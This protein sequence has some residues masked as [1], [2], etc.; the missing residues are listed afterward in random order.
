MKPRVK[1]I[2]LGHSF[3]MKYFSQNVALGSAFLFFLLTMHGLAQN[4]KRVLF[5]GNSY[6]QVNNLPQLLAD[7]AASTGDSLIS[8]RSTPGGYTLQLHT[9]NTSSVG[10]IMQGN[11][12]MVVLQEQSQLPS[13][14]I[15]QVITDVF[16]YARFLD[17]LINIYNPCGETVFYRTWGRK[18]G[19][20]SNCSWW[21]PVCTYQGMD[22]L[23]QLRYMMMADSNQAIVSPVGAVWNYIRQYYPDIELYQM[24]ESHPSQAGS[25]AAACSFYTAIFRK[26][27]MLIEYNYTLTEDDAERIRA[28]AKEIVF[29]RLGF[30]HV[31]EF[32]PIANFEY[33]PDNLS[34]E[35]TNLSYQASCYS[36]DF[37]DGEQSD[38]TDPT[39]IFA[40]YGTYD[41]RLVAMGNGF[42]DTVISQVTVV[43]TGTNQ[44]PIIEKASVFPNPVEDELQIDL[45]KGKIMRITL[46]DESGVSTQVKFESTSQGV[47]LD[48]KQLSPGF[49][50]I[51]VVTD[52][53]TNVYKVIKK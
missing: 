11:W 45:P 48:L 20:A 31:G 43:M 44:Y 9:T 15:E 53:G 35:F 7:V 17:S 50:V 24:D 42:S 37:G 33:I 4:T 36:W 38:E 13:F 51:T 46:A 21:P 8:D 49:Y 5:L 18:N 1:I 6:T 22:S 12:D 19:D 40:S 32:D 2:C 39:H 26:N 28:A 16:P 3:Y 30:W 25:Y 14:P 34:V 10:K 52:L 29:D 41:V 27:P 23:L 47:K